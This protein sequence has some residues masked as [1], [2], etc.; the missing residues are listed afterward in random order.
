MT[1]CVGVRYVYDVLFGELRSLFFRFEIIRWEV[2]INSV[3]FMSKLNECIAKI[4][5][6]NATTT[7]NQDSFHAE[8]I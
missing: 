7:K 6:Y 8:I 3:S 2:H 5:A 4:P 1:E